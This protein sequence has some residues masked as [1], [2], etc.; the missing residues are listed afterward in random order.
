MNSQQCQDFEYLAGLSSDFIMKFGTDEQLTY[1]NEAGRSTLGLTEGN[2]LE[3]L[4]LLLYS[5]DGT[6]LRMG[7][8]REAIDSLTSGKLTQQSIPCMLS[9]DPHRIGELLLT[10]SSDQVLVVYKSGE[11]HGW[12]G[13]DLENV[14]DF[15]SLNSWSYNEQTQDFWLSE[16]ARSLLQ[17]PEG[18]VLRA[19]NVDGLF[20]EGDFAYLVAS[21]S[22]ATAAGQPVTT[23]MRTYE[24]NQIWVRVRFISER[25]VSGKEKLIQ[26]VFQD[27][28]ATE[29]QAMMLRRQ[30]HELEVSHRLL[31]RAER[32]TKLG[33]WTLSKQAGV[34]E[35]SDEV[36]QICELPPDTRLDM[37][38]FEVFINPDHI[39]WA[40]GELPKPGQYVHRII[41]GWNQKWVEVNVD[42]KYEDSQVVFGTIQD[43]TEEVKAKQ[44]ALNNEAKQKAI[45]DTIPNPF[46]FTDTNGQV[47]Q[48]NQAF[49]EFVGLSRHRIIGQSLYAVVNFEETEK[50]TKTDKLM[51][52]GTLK[53]SVTETEVLVG[54][55]KRTIKLHKSTFFN[56]NDRVMGLIGIFYDITSELTTNARLS[57]ANKQFA[58]A[59]SGANAGFFIYDIPRDINYWDRKSAEIFGLPPE[60]HVGNLSEFLQ[61]VIPQDRRKLRGEYNREYDNADR[62]ENNYRINRNGEIRHIHA[63]GSVERNEQGKPIKIVGI[64]I[65]ETS[66]VRARQRL[67]QSERKY[68]RI[69]ESIKD[70]YLM[71]DPEGIILNANPAAA[72]MLGYRIPSQLIGRNFSKIA[73][74][75]S[76]NLKYFRSELMQQK[77]LENVRLELRR[78]DGEQIIANFYAALQSENGK[79]IVE[80]TFR[81]VTR[82][83]QTQEQIIA[84]TI[85]AEDKQ[86]KRIAQE[87]HDSVQQ[88]L[89]TA[90]MN[91]E[92]IAHRV[93][94]LGENIRRNFDVG[95]K[96]LD[97]G[98]M[99]SRSVSYDLMPAAVEDF[100][101][102]AATETLV[103]TMRRASNIDFFYMTNLTNERLPGTVELSLYRILQESCNNVIKYSKASEVHVN[104]TLKD[105]LLT[106]TVED[107]GVGFDVFKTTTDKTFGLTSMK[108]R[109]T[110]IGAHFEV[111]SGAQGTMVMVELK[112]KAID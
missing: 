36:Y 5:L 87:L 62:F 30:K 83:I 41:A 18:Y 15:S 105:G 73:N 59:I 95:L 80:A 45:I 71:V 9:S 56:S 50:L 54:E 34:F 4:M 84:A 74:E 3:E 33:H 17:L 98:L 8:V 75:P 39:N 28:T 82:E 57:L 66:Q 79:H 2:T 51:L 107:N 90:K 100:G 106:L 58:L 7:L 92:S 21:F 27:I 68:R 88:L 48:V 102:A 70:G 38:T 6:S 25:I 65:D 63:Q 24:G 96:F 52:F 85:N 93:D 40:K 20:D 112:V 109:A 46:F 22:Q 76:V 42:P 60:P 78:K 89:I 53:D 94:E 69:F 16:S 64:H 108:N 12:S 81:D 110:S 49:C 19:D 37:P 14:M 111:N 72:T 55:K 26:G 97:E 32:I 99:E 61:C 43:I 11:F 104:L 1:I 13:E 77:E 103:N 29:E 67:E 23:R 91:L 44:K 86:R 101:I 35:V 10:P 31:T 47:R